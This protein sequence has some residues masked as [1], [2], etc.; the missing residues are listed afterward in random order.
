MLATPSMYLAEFVLGR[1][2]HTMTK[3]ETAARHWADGAA[4]EAIASGRPVV[5]SSGI[6]PSGEIHIGNMREVLT[7]DA[8]FR[9]VKDRGVPARFNYVCDN[10]DPLRHV[11]PFLD[12]EVYAPLIGQPLAAIP[13]P[14]G[15]HPS[16]AEHFLEP[17]LASLRALHVDVELERAD[18]IYASG[19]MNPTI[20]L[21][22][23]GRD[24]I[25]VI[26]HEL[27]GKAIDAAWSPFNPLC[28]SCRRITKSTVT[29]FSV[30]DETISYACAC[31][32]SGEMPMAGGGK[33]TWRVDWPARWA[34]L[35]VTVEPFG[36]DHATRGGSYDTGA[37][38]AREVF[39]TEPPL[40]VPYEWI[41]LKGRGDMSSSKGNVLSI[42]QVLDL[43]PPE[44]LRY[45]VMRERPQSTISFDPGLP[46]LQLVDEVDDATASGVDSRALEL[47]RAA[48]FRAVGVPFKHLIVAAQVA[49]FD[50]ERTMDVLARTGYHGLDAATVGSRLGCARRWLD[51]HAPEEI[52]FEVKKTLPPEAGAL[53][54]DQ[55]SFLGR[56]GSRLEDAMDGEAI[57][58][59]VYELAKE[60]P[61]TKPAQLFQ[62]LYI[63]L[64]AKPRGPRAG[65]FIR[66]LGPRLC[67]DRFLEASAV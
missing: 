43:A 50:V 34:M 9:A 12:A 48:G 47:S 4:E 58:L 10:L 2:K 26:L 29:G 13:C 17:F 28:P 60:F 33:L 42:G 22:L 41:S 65:T 63:A 51:R 7:A 3:G 5:V 39:D 52:R 57:H 44:V 21:A 27:T 16:Y 20:S 56:L 31:G 61:G 30:R 35:G 24:R 54:P 38:I 23:T 11:Y 6:S 59:L 15:A 14:C 1:E 19:R 64:L 40:P 55:K 53:T 67:A 8:V 37:R 66:A 49:G 32:S 45:L 36:K 25:A 46:L 62:A 18:R